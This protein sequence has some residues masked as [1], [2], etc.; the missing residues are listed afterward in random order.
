MPKHTR[1]MTHITW[2]LF[3]WKLLFSYRSLNSPEFQ[4]K[5]HCPFATSTSLYKILVLFSRSINRMSIVWDIRVIVN[6]QMSWLSIDTEVAFLSVP[7]HCDLCFTCHIL[8]TTSLLLLQGRI[9]QC[10]VYLL[11]F[12]YLYLQRLLFCHV[13]IFSLTLERYQ[14]CIV[15]S[16]NCIN[17]SYSLDDQIKRRRTLTGRILVIRYLRMISP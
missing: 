17:S 2:N 9:N 11:V 7:M 6:S 1:N 12:D 8:N 15:L 5:L 10:G 4:L 14:S 16:L 3:V 13:A